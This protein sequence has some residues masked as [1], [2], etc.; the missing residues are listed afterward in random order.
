MHGRGQRTFANGDV[1]V[2]K[3]RYGQRCGGPDCKLK[4]ANGDLYVG[5]WDANQFHGFGRYYFAGG[6]ALAGYFEHGKKHG[7]FKRQQPSGDLDILR[8][9]SD[10]VVGQG[11]RWNV[12]RTKTWLLRTVVDK[13]QHNAHHRRV[14]SEDRSQ[15]SNV[16]QNNGDRDR[17]R[18]S[19]SPSLSS[20]IRRSG[21]FRQGSSSSLVSME[22]LVE[23]Q[24]MTVTK[25][26]GRIPIAQA[27][28][29]GYDCEL[30]GEIR[31]TNPVFWSFG[32]FS[33]NS[34]GR[35]PNDSTRSFV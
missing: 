14:Q 7:K 23:T 1:Y 33:N 24:A 27:V 35:G 29:I 5:S 11:V 17:R 34:S 22:P 30:G 2:G 26:G 25:K 8:Y 16:D 3:Y 12:A 10:Q 31:D 28:S 21:I 20:R 9:E 13:R 18:R 19:S 15:T 6:T 32:D 4:F